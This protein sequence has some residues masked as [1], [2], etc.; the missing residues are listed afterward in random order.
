MQAEL[1]GDT[2]DRRISEIGDE[3]ANG[4]LLKSLPEVCKNQYRPGCM[5]NSFAYGRRLASMLTAY[6]RP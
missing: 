1:T 5:P 3:P 2:P 4:G 6:Y